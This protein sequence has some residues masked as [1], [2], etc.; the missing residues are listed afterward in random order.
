MDIS[1]SHNDVNFIMSIPVPELHNTYPGGNVQSHIL[2]HKVWATDETSI[3]STI[4]NT[5]KGLVVDVGANTGYFSFIALSK[6]CRVISFEPNTIHTPYFMKTLELNNFNKEYISHY[7]YFVSSSDKEI[8][9]DGWSAYDGIVNKDNSKYVKTIALKDICNECLFL[10]IDVEGFEPD[11]LK[12]A[13]PLLEYGKIDYIMFEITYIINNRIDNNQ[14]DMLN[15]LVTYGYDIFE[16]VAGKIIRIS[17]ISQ[18][19]AT[20][21]E[22]YF[23]THKKYNPSL[24]SAGS[25]LFA[26]YKTAVN[27]FNKLNINEFQIP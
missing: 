5:K 17:D 13:A 18:K 20:W 11:V 26:I 8:L 7:E 25:N 6:G 14:C 27:P 22:E 12:S 24:T 19:L 2:D 23:N 1:I 16:I 15:S 9:F 21:N 4:L 3:L 10:K